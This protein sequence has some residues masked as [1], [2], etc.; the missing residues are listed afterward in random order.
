MPETTA[1]RTHAYGSS[2]E[3][4]ADL[5]V[6]DGAPPAAGWPVVVLVH[7]GFWRDQYRRDLMVPLAEDLARRGVATWNVE[8]RRVGPTGGG[9]PATLADVAAA[10]DELAVVA[11][12][13]PLDLDRVA[14]VGH[15]AGGHLALW[16][17]G[18]TVLP[19]GVVGAAPQV[20]P[21]AAVAQA[22]V[23]SLAAGGA[24][25]DGAVADFVGGTPDEVP[26]RYALADPVGLVG[27][28]VPVLLVHGEEDDT[29]PI[30][31]AERYVAAAS[32]AGDPVRL[33]R[34]PGDHMA[35]IDP[36]G[37]LWASAVAFV[38]ERC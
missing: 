16:I 9:V 13:G 6:P 31:Q 23:A 29:V 2:P 18:R 28:G 3:Q 24:L 11:G 32:A 10:V 7:G 26:D 30:D 15:S 22:A 25:G 38:E 14:V 34:L 19:D 12:D 5:R 27:H 36:E 35:V 8:Y 21:C 17:V 4:V 37:A 33:E 1:V 20:V